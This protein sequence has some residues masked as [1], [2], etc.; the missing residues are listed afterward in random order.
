MGAVSSDTYWESLV[1]AYRYLRDLDLGDPEVRHDPEVH[2]NLRR[3]GIHTDGLGLDLYWSRV[4]W[5]ADQCLGAVLDIG[6]STGN[7]TKWILRRPGVEA[8]TAVEIVP[9]LAAACRE[10]ADPRL[11]VQTGPLTASALR[12]AYDTVLLGEVIEHMDIATE[13]KLLAD[14]LSR[15]AVR[16]FVITTPHGYMQDPDHRR[17]FTQWQLDAHVRLLYGDPIGWWSN[18]VQQGVRVRR[19]DRGPVARGMASVLALFTTVRFWSYRYL[20]LRPIRAVVR[21][22][23]RRLRRAVGSRLPS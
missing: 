16:E 23:A 19:V 18:G 6:A 10:I 11:D 3:L 22:L 21:P 7:V 1:E 14:L 5:T 20:A 8:V 17:G 15:C 4:E 12:D 9:Q 13:R 2:A